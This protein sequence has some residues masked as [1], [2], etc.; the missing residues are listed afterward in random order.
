MTVLPQH[1]HPQANEKHW[2]LLRLSFRRYVDKVE[3]NLQA[4][5]NAASL[6]HKLKVMKSNLEK[7]SVQSGKQC[8]N[9]PLYSG[10]WSRLKVL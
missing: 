5:K 6:R 7:L 3:L 2:F 8:N 10:D 1:T 4:K 9:H